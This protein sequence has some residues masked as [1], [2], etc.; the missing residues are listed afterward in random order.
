M[1]ERIQWSA[2]LPAGAA[3]DTQ[4][5]IGLVPEGKKLICTA[6]SYYGGDAGE[7]YLLN[8]VP[9]GVFPVQGTTVDATDGTVNW[10][11]PLG[12]GSYAVEH[13]FNAT[14]E[15]GNA[16]ANPVPG[17]ATLTISCQAES[18]AALVV[19]ILGILEDL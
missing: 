8:L 2:E 5:I 1:G 9:S 14:W 17:P 7:R 10:V 11:Y 12:G 15:S 13:P 6:V 16:G 4:Y 3:A 18:T 19:N